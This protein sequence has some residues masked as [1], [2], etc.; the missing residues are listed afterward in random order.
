[1]EISCLVV[2]QET[3]EEKN[4]NCSYLEFQWNGIDRGPVE[5][6][7]QNDPFAE[8]DRYQEPIGTKGPITLK[9]FTGWRR[10]EKGKRVPKTT[11]VVV[12]CKFC[13]N[14]KWAFDHPFSN[15]LGKVVCPVLRRYK[16]P[17]C[18][19]TGGDAHTLKYCPKKTIY[20]QDDLRAVDVDGK[21]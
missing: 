20:T 6:Q 10:R 19:A 1:M 15:A 11:T 4:Q 5:Q 14:N 21:R 8:M 7:T 18:G 2:V 13:K 17:I 12:E 16:C 3:E 9:N